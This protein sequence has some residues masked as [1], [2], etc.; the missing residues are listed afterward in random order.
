MA[1]INIRRMILVSE[2][3][4]LNG[5]FE[6][7]EDLLVKEEPRL[8]AE[9]NNLQSN[10]NNLR[11][12]KRSSILDDI[13]DE[14]GESFE[15]EKL[16]EEEEFLADKLS[17]FQEMFDVWQRSYFTTMYSFLESELIKEC[18]HQ[19]SDNVLLTLADLSG[20]NEIDKVKIYFTKVLKIPFPS[21]TPEWQEIQNYR[22][23]RNCI[24]H[25][26]G[27]VDDDKNRRLQDYI[28]QQ[29]N[30]RLSSGNVILSKSFCLEASNT[31]KTF[32]L[33]LM[34]DEQ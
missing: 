16:V 14:E 23:L 33:M 28:T 17:S 27:R 3:N 29:E 2:F 26:R 21:N 12:K 5:Y 9:L 34:S 7:I 25:N 30:L 8:L 15:E 22:M 24:V 32:L 31:I 10:L 19:K 18:L 6:T 1:S 13:L 20:Q 11:T 4:L